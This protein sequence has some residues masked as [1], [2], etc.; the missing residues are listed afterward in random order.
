MSP[1]PVMHVLCLAAAGFLLIACEKRATAPA[2]QAPP[3]TP[4]PG[5]AGIPTPTPSATATPPVEQVSTP[6]E[7]NTRAEDAG[8][9]AVRAEVL[10]RID[11]MPNLGGEEKDKLYVQV[12]RAQAMGKVITIPFASGARTVPA[13]AVAGISKALTLPQVLKYS[14]DP[15]V[16]FV[17][18]GFADKKGDPKLNKV[19]SLQRAEAVASVLKDKAGVVN[20]VRAVG[21]GGSEIFDSAALDKNRVVEVWVVLP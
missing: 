21:M 14:E 5:F 10:K 20:I 15:T 6:Q 8:N 1:R 16:V 3:A 18:L 9:R 7:I 4:E 2:P 17:V 19:I 11:V 13:E 12:E